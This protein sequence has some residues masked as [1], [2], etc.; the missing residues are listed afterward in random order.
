MNRDK[1]TLKK[2]QEVLEFAW[3]N[4]YSSFY[5][6]KYKKAGIKSI[7]EINTW[8]DFEKLPFLTRDEIIEAGPNNFFFLPRDKIS[9]VAFSSG[10]TN[11]NQP[12]IIYHSF[13]DQEI[14]RRIHKKYEEL[15]LKSMMMLFNPFSALIR[16]MLDTEMLGKKPIITL[17][18]I[19]NLELS[20]KIAARLEIDGIKTTPSVL[21]R[22]VPYLEKEYDLEK[23]RLVALG[24]EFC[25]EQQANYLRA[26]F[27]KAF[28]EF[29]FGGVE[30]NDK[31]YR[32]DTLSSFH[33]RFFHAESK[34]FYYETKDYKGQDELVLTHLIEFGNLLIRYKTGDAVRLYEEK[35]KC[36][37]TLQMEVFGRLEYDVIKIQGTFIYS[38]LISRALAHFGQFLAS[39]EWKLHVFE[40]KANG[41]IIP[42][43]KLQILPNSKVK[44]DVKIKKLIQEGISKNLFVSA[45]YTLWDLVKKDVFM[46]LEIEYLDEFPFE[47]KQKN[48]IS[49][50]T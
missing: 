42:R 45:N 15:N 35:C 48:I 34:T 31:G 10:T 44:K 16:L 40:E 8:E 26:T 9:N 17:G 6:D 24:G 18:D 38:E 50:L 39:N 19:N 27:R 36:K 7:K 49:H 11:K 28:F 25:S 22:L 5:K 2:I 21:S 1:R 29:G 12:L 47:S 3:N 4:P 13:F 23:I 33:P 20:A 41:K 30:T 37:N 43:L 14:Y 32:C 46:P